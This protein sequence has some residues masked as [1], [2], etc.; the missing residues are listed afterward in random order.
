MCSMSYFRTSMQGKNEVLIATMCKYD[1]QMFGNT[2][3]S[4]VFM[5]G[6]LVWDIFW[7]FFSTDLVKEIPPLWEHHFGLILA[8]VSPKAG[9]W[10][11]YFFVEVLMIG[12]ALGVYSNGLVVP[13]EEPSPVLASFS[14][15]TLGKRLVVRFLG[16]TFTATREEFRDWVRNQMNIYKL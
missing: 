4:S 16:G 3:S 10:S 14:L 9:D 6:S 5:S 15:G 11:K 2:W 1:R 12:S 7:V 13:G 8:S